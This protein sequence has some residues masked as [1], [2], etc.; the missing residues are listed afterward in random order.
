MKK[1]IVMMFAAA[2][3]AGCSADE[4]SNINNGND[5]GSATVEETASYITVS[6]DEG[7]GIMATSAANARSS[8]L[9]KVYQGWVKSTSNGN[10]N[11]NWRQWCS[12]CGGYCFHWNSGLK[13]WECLCGNGNDCKNC[14]SKDDVCTPCYEGDPAEYDHSCDENAPDQGGDEDGGD[15]GDG[16]DGGNEDGGDT[17]D[18]GNEDGGDTGDEDS[19]VSIDFDIDLSDVLDQ[20]FTMETDDFYIRINGDYIESATWIDGVKSTSNKALIGID[21]NDNLRI[22]IIGL[23]QI[24]TDKAG[25]DY[26]FEAYLWVKNEAPLN[27][28]TGGTGQLFDEKMKEKWVN[29]ED[30]QDSEAGCNINVPEGKGDGLDRTQLTNRPEYGY[31][32]RYNVYRGISGRPTTNGEGDYISKYGDT[33]YIK[34]SVHVKRVADT[35]KSTFTP[36]YYTW[37]EK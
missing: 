4:I 11:G 34:V 3:L 31:E 26:T 30:G 7:I 22:S 21:G 29:Y 13:I 2:L 28:G 16:G 18:G 24:P 5:N 17:G 8:K 19:D 27:D 25:Y 20:A 36:I 15:T 23:E 37:E 32:V 6:T 14:D 12:Q 1:Q 9:D 35:V 33:P 10:G